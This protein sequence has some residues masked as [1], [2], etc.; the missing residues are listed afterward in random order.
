VVPGA[1]AAIGYVLLFKIFLNFDRQQT[2]DHYE[3]N[4]YLRGSYI[5]LGVVFILSVFAAF[6]F[7][8]RKAK[9]NNQT[10]L[11]PTAR[12]AIINFCIPM[13]VGAFYFL[14]TL[15]KSGPA[16]ALHNFYSQ[17]LVF[18]GLALINCSKYSILQ[19]RILGF[20]ECGL[21]ILSLLFYPHSL[22]MLG[23]GVTN[24]IFGIIVLKKENA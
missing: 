21:G 4:N 11:D 17:S 1:F 23:F 22:W 19:L 6:W 9:K 8:N 13:L 5:V 10:L 24:I 16:I 3:I 12:R 15:I 18:Y 2:K 20:A 7:N 14:S